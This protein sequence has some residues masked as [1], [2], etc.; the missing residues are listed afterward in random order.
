MNSKRF[1]I[2]LLITGLMALFVLGVSVRRYVWDAQVRLLGPDIPFTLE[3]ALQYRLAETL[4]ETGRIPNDDLDIQYPDGITVHETYTLGA[5]YVFVPLSRLFPGGMTLADKLRW[6]QV[7]WFCLGVPMMAV[8]VFGMSRSWRAGFFAGM[9]YAVCLAAVL[10][11][12]GQEL[13]RENFALPLLIAHL[14]LTALAAREKGR[15]RWLMALGSMLTLAWAAISWDL[16]QF[17]VTLWA[18][19]A[20]WR[21]LREHWMPADWPARLWML[22]FAGLFAANLAT[23]YARAHGTV[24]SPGMLIGCGCFLG[25]MFNR[26]GFTWMKHPRPWRFIV[27]LLPL[28]IGLLAAL[29]Y[30]EAYGH[31]AELFLAKVR[32]LNRKP[33]DPA[34]LTFN[35]RILWVPAL[36]SATWRLT[37]MHFPAILILTLISALTLI[38]N[39]ISNPKSERFLIL[40]FCGVSLAAYILFVRFYVFLVIFAIGLSGLWLADQLSRRGFV[41]WVALLL[42]IAT[43]SIEA[44]H[45]LR[46][47]EFWGRTGV[48]YAELDEMAQWLREH[49][50]PQPVLANFG[51]SGFI[52]AYGQCPIVLHP[53]FE[54]AEIRARVRG[55]GEALFKG[56]EKEFRDWADEYGAKYYV[57][58]RGEL[59]R[60][61]PERQMRYF[62]NALNPAA[63][64][65]VRVFEER[66]RRARYFRLEWEN[67]KY[68]VFR[69]LTGAEEKRAGRHAELAKERLSY[70]DIEGAELQAEAALELD[71]LN[72]TAARVIEH[73][74]NLRKKGFSYR[75]EEDGNEHQ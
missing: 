16:I 38:H 28:T 52:S 43:V 55:Y 12:T 41:R 15:G 34:L 48:Y 61:F 49:V 14:A 71:P 65:A 5:E 64:S 53:K 70:G 11:S 10:R 18:I 72:K 69:I 30:R 23:P 27:V 51:V 68:R 6:L 17:Y 56:T 42:A 1:S 31:F 47:P 44:M 20:C 63:E 57:H 7:F 32:F 8:W 24:L 13:S 3:S 37:I 19:G 40:F 35:Q 54:S 58:S 4:A 2:I 25:I 22:Q 36:N 75:I 29:H 66:P 33:A 45:T 50:K 73:T 9:L 46:H 60:F 26:F 62:V 74:V 59:Y 67:R 21:M 39:Q